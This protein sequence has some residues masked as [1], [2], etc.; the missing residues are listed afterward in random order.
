MDKKRAS[1]ASGGSASKKG[2]PDA[3]KIEWEQKFADVDVKALTEALQKHGGKVVGAEELFCI[4]FFTIP[5]TSTFQDGS[6]VRVMDDRHVSGF[7]RVRKEG[8]Q[9]S[10]TIKKF[11]MV[12]EKKMAEEFEVKVDSFTNACDLLLAAGF[13][14]QQFQEK[15]RQTWTVPSMGIKEVVVDVYPGLNAYV[16][17]ECASEDAMNQATEALGFD[18]AHAITGT[19]D[20]VYAKEYGMDASIFHQDGATFGFHNTVEALKPH[21]KTNMA[22]FEQIAKAQQDAGL[23]GTYSH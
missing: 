14:K 20:D 15:F 9:I 23:K 8:P 2:K 19:T 12:G 10:L 16:E 4:Q 1:D 18:P 7:G 17:I 11:I 13:K 6:S 5:N 21:V 3:S 22:K